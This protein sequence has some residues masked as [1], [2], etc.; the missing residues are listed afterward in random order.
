MKR[1]AL[2]IGGLAIS[3]VL[4]GGWALA[5]SFG[6]G[7]SGFGPPFMHGKGFQGK[8]PGMMQ[9]M[10]PGMGKGMGPGMMRMGHDQ[11]TM[12]QM[13]DIHALL[14]KHDRVKRTVTNLPDGIRT[15]TESDDPQVAELIKTHVAQMG[16]RV[17][18]GDDPGLPIESPALRAIFQYKDKINTTYETTATGIVVTQTSTDPKA[19]AVLQEHAAEVTDLVKGGMPALHAAMMRNHGGMM[20]GM[21]H[22]RMVHGGQGGNRPPSTR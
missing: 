10:G 1:K 16:Q 14:I 2:I 13:G 11:A 6:H 3:G 17:Q 15:V 19:V 8:G 18:A 4:V 20:G 9:H 21:M 7:P 12:A 22:G 5:Q